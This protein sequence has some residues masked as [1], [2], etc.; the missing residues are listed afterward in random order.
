MSAQKT[1][2]KITL[3]DSAIRICFMAIVTSLLASCAGYK[4]IISSDEENDGWTLVKVDK[5]DNPSWQA[6]TRKLSGTNFIE[7]KIEGNISL[8]P[9]ACLS[10]FNKDIHALANGSQVKKYPIYEIVKES[11]DSLLTYVIHNEPYPLKDTEMSAQY[12]YFSDENGRTGVSWYEAW[13]ECFIEPSRKLNRVET[14]RGSWSFSPIPTSSTKAVTT[15]QFDPKK[16]PRSL[17][18]P[19]VIKFLR[20]GLEDLR[21]KT[22]EKNI[23][24]NANNKNN[25][26]RK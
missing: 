20:G 1:H 24:S 21:K 18:E 15:V 23:A 2:K 25:L 8:S 10:S 7:Y 4:H 26:T 14:F 5:D 9:E 17:V 3:V 12:I 19:M 11:G 16:M 22:P 6:F 13:N